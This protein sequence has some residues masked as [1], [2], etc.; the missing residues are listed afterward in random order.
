MATIQSVVTHS[1]LCAWENKHSSHII[2]VCVQLGKTPREGNLATTTKI[3]NAYTHGP[4]ISHGFIPRTHLLGQWHEFK[5][6]FSYFDCCIVIIHNGGIH[7]NM[8]R[9]S[10]I[11]L[12]IPP[13][14][15]PPHRPPSLPLLVSLPFLWD[16]VIYC[17][18]SFTVKVWKQ[19]KVH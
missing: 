18:T 9:I 11:P 2:C 6:I 1:V 4:P 16:K 17:S 15:L 10:S 14:Y 13:F 5:A 3:P 7:S 8:H 12:P 19:Y